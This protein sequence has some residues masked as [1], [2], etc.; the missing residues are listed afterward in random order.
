LF[1][2]ASATF[3]Q[4]IR[5]MLKLEFIKTVLTESKVNFGYLS[6]KTDQDYQVLKMK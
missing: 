6:N 3:A 1:L 4:N 5:E 2:C